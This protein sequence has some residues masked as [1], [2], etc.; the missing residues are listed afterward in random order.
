MEKIEELKVDNLSFSYQNQKEMSIW[1]IEFDE[2]LLKDNRIGTSYR[3]TIIKNMLRLQSQQND[4]LLEVIQNNLKET[5][6]KT[7]QIDHLGN[8]YPRFE[9]I[10]DIGQTQ[11]FNFEPL[12]NI[13]DDSIFNI[14]KLKKTI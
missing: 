5:I 3:P 8:I 7:I 12:G 2:L 6:L 9:A 14:I 13:K 10:G 11:R 4:S 1:L